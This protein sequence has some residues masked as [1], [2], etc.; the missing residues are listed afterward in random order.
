MNGGFYQSWFPSF[1][2][3]ENFTVSAF[4]ERLSIVAL[5]THV[6]FPRTIFG[7]AQKPSTTSDM[8]VSTTVPVQICRRLTASTPTLPGTEPKNHRTGGARWGR[9]MEN[10]Q[11]NAPGLACNWLNNPKCA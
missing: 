1:P 2:F 8:P 9:K 4:D 5:R 3:V 6:Y 7:A 11:A 10:P